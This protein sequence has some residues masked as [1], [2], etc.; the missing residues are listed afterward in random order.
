MLI[1]VTNMKNIFKAISILV[2]LGAI[3]GAVILVKNNQETRRGATFA[4]VE[5]LF[6]PDSKTVEVGDKFTSTLV[7]DTKGRQLTGADFRIK[8]DNQK[9]RLTGIEVLSKDNFKS[10]VP[11]LQN[12][13]ELIVSEVD[14]RNGWIN[15]VGTN[16]QKDATMLPT[17]IVNMVRLNFVGKMAG[18][19]NVGI[20]VSYKNSITGYNPSGTDQDLNIEVVRG[21]VYKVVERAEVKC[22]WCGTRCIDTNREKN[23]VCTQ[24]IMEG[25]QCVNEGGM[26]VVVK[27]PISIAPTKGVTTPKPVMTCNLS[28][29]PPKNC[30]AGYVCETK[31]GMAGASGIC[32]QRKIVY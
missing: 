20:D 3:V 6:L 23:I 28:I 2:V 31:S 5:A 7:L 24:E 15:L 17:G 11:W 26:C 1:W 32:V 10:G 8:Y 29:N 12:S 25:K 18:E 4:N 16:L 19:A 27:T 22:G 13:D 9:L 30:P 14:E 21:A